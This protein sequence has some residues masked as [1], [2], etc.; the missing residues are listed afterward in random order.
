MIA[1]SVGPKSL[2]SHVN[3][4]SALISGVDTLLSADGFHF[5]VV[6]K[7][8]PFTALSA[9][10]PHPLH[11]LTSEEQLSVKALK[12]WANSSN[13]KVVM[14]D[15]SVN[16]LP[17]LERATILI[18]DLDSSIPFEYLYFCSEKTPK[19]L[20]A[21]YDAGNAPQIALSDTSYMAL[22]NTFTTPLEFFGVVDAVLNPARASL[23]LVTAGVEGHAFFAN[24]YSEPDGKEVEKMAAVRKWKEVPPLLL[25]LSSLHSFIKFNLL[26]PLLF[27]YF[28]ST[29]S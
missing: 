23:K 13:G 21:Y 11:S 12:E 10:P 9:Q 16:A 24:K 14:L 6:I 25:F 2:L 4:L 20:L 17:L 5:R 8:H 18:C 19:Q 7:M 27:L 22:I 26:F 15:A 1:P 29:S 3:V 28:P